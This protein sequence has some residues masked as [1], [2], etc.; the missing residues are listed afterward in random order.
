MTDITTRALH[1]VAEARERRLERELLAIWA[2]VRSGNPA[3]LTELEVL[4]AVEDVRRERDALRAE[5]ERLRARKAEVCDCV[6]ATGMIGESFVD[7]DDDCPNCGG[8]GAVFVE[9]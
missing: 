1:S 5:V 9:G 4:H 3:P 8:S 2:T 7:V 6:H